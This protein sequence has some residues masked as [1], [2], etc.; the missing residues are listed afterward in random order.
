MVALYNGYRTPFVVL[1]V[2]IAVVAA[3][4]HQTT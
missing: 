3:L 2:P 1:A 4:M